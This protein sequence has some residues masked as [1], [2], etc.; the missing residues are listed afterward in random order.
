MCIRDRTTA[1]ATTATEKP[2]QRADG[3]R[4]DD[5]DGDDGNGDD[6]HGETCA[7]RRWG[8]LLYTSP[9]P[10]DRSLS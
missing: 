1:T 5:D 2:A 8:C 3:G 7:A 6:G 9:S 10:R 4:D